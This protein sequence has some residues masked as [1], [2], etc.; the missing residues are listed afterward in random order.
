MTPERATTAV[1]QTAQAPKP[2]EETIPLRP[3]V[4]LI[5]CLMLGGCLLRGDLAAALGRLLYLVHLAVLLWWLLDKSPRQRATTG[6]AATRLAEVRAWIA[7]REA[8]NHPHLERYRP[9][10]ARP[11]RSVDL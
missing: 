6:L 11:D 8:Q 1:T 9:A 10:G 2:T 7:K 5:A 4:G 3:G